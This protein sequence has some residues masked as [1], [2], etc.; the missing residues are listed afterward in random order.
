MLP[1]QLIDLF[2][3]VQ[4]GRYVCVKM[5]GGGTERASLHHTVPVSTVNYLLGMGDQIKRYCE[6]LER[7][8]YDEVVDN[9]ARLE[10]EEIYTDLNCY[11]TQDRGREVSVCRCHTDKCN[12]SPHLAPSTAIIISASVCWGLKYLW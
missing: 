11:P 2:S 3:I 1:R 9:E 6:K 12:A 10:A 5:Y 8:E 4:D 7:E